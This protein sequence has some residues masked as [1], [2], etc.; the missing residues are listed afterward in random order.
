MFNRTKKL[1][2]TALE[3]G[4]IVVLA[5]EEYEVENPNFVTITTMSYAPVNRHVILKRKPTSKSSDSE[6]VSL[7]IPPWY[8]MRIRKKK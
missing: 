8:P 4:D 6:R 1:N 2:A 7:I 5:D 3:V